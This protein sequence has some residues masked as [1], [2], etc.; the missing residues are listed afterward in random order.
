MTYFYGF[1]MVL[2]KEILF[3]ERLCGSFHFAP[4]KTQGLRRAVPALWLHRE[5]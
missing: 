1:Q 4:D 5:A 2:T 3:E